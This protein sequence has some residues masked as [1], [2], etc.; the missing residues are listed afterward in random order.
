MGKMS[1]QKG[2]T[3]EREVA[4]LLRK[5]GFAG[6][7]GVQYQGGPDSADVTGLPG[8]HV[9]VKRT[10]RMSIYPA[11]DQA[12]DEKADHEK[13]VVF[14]RTNGSYWVAI[15]DARDFLQLVSATVTRTA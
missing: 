3:G 8:W 4:A 12:A 10:E 14:H 9:E 11:M 13:P 15:L 1:R 5:H 2:K 7:R 6:Q